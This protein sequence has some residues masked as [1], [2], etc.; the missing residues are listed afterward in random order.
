MTLLRAKQGLLVQST[1]LLEFMRKH[2][3]PYALKLVYEQAREA[4]NY[5]SREL[6]EHETTAEGFEDDGDGFESAGGAERYV[7]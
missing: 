6:P 7:Y 1:P 5:L 2:V 3:N 4:G